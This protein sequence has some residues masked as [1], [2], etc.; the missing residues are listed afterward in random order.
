MNISLELLKIKAVFLRP[1]DPF[2]WA[3]GIKSPI[4]CDNRLTLGYPKLRKDIA[5]QLS[6]IIKNKY[7][8]VNLIVGT[9]TAG[10]PHATLISDILNKPLG[11][12]RSSNKNHGRQNQFEGNLIKGNVIVVEDLISTGKSSLEV[13][14]CLKEL[15][16]NVLGV[17]SIFSYELESGIN[18]FRNNDIEYDSL[19]NFY[20]L[21]KIALKNNYINK[22]EYNKLLKW[23]IN[24]NDESWIKY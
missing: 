3:S 4:Y 12:V 7:K 2:I 11:Y 21:I 15:G 18:N 6:N 24:P 17:I 23:H 20:E 9:A 14:D 1:N 10:I 5:L 16:F 8:N 22:E 19:S 13:C